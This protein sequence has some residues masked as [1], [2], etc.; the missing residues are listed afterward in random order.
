MNSSN[1]GGRTFRRLHGLIRHWQDKK[2]TFPAGSENAFDWKLNKVVG[3]GELEA[4]GDAIYLTGGQFFVQN[5]SDVHEDD[6]V[7]VEIV[8]EA[9]Q[10][11]VNVFIPKV[12]VNIGSNSRAFKLD[13]ETSSKLDLTLGLLFRIKYDSKGAVPIKFIAALEY[14][15]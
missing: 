9:S 3:E 10:Q 2:H 6:T 1:T 5:G 14:Y 12:Y 8:H 15:G 11:V 13:E 4:S 7:R